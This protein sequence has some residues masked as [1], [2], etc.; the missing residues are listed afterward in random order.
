MIGIKSI[1]NLILFVCYINDMP[2]VEDSPVYMFVDDNKIYRHITSQSDKEALQARGTTS[3][4]HY[5]QEA[6]QARGTTSKR[7]YKQE[8]LQARGTTSKRHYK[9]EALQARGTTSKRHYKQEALQADL[10][11]LEVWSRKWQL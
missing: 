10:T 5:K 6:L 9:Q 3:K 1:I 11:Q 4:R 8:A 7:P 2:D